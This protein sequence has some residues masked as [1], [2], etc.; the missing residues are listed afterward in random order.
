M[1]LVSNMITQKYFLKCERK[2]PSTHNFR[3]FSYV[4]E[5][6]T[7]LVLDSRRKEI[8]INFIPIKI[9]EHNSSLFL[10]IKATSN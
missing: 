3:G 7:V 9:L 10:N 4:R 6:L 5:T 1:V 2:Q 8:K